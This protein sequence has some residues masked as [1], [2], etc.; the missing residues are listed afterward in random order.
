MRGRHRE[1][2][3]QAKVAKETV[4]PLRRR[5]ME[6]ESSLAHEKEYSEK[7]EEC[8]KESD[9]YH[10]QDTRRRVE[11]WEAQQADNEQW[12][13]ER[14]SEH[15]AAI[16]AYEEKFKQLQAEYEQIHK[17]EVASHD[18]AILQLQSDYEQVRNF[19][20]HKASESVSKA[21]RGGNIRK[22]LQV[23]RLAAMRVQAIWRGVLHRRH[24][25]R[26][27]ACA[28]MVQCSWRRKCGQ[29]KWRKILAEAKAQRLRQV[30]AA[31]GSSMA[32][33]R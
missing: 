30:T 16:D 5:V 10:Q 12:W 2:M 7:L 31:S 14:Q 29:R 22:A 8:I 3:M 25:R 11:S 17:E 4:A 32:R 15:L 6:L 33:R 24:L 21:Y 9:E 18:A 26:L 19:A 20:R 1:A 23:K 28:T 13:K 27:E